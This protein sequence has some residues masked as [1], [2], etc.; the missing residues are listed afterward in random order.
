MWRWMRG[1]PARKRAHAAAYAQLLEENRRLRATLIR[2]QYRCAQLQ[3]QVDA[4]VT[5]ARAQGV[6]RVK[7]RTEDM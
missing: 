7:P 5:G 1:W 4:L 3:L 2:A 6:R